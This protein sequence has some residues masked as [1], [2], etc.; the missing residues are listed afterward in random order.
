MR[1]SCAFATSFE[2]PGHVQLAE[3]RG[4]RLAVPGG[5]LVHALEAS[6][7]AVRETVAT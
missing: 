7:G 6:M 2:T 4:Y 1:I 3:R 5:H